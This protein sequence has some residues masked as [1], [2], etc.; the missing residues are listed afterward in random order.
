[1]VV[2]GGAI[3]ELVALCKTGSEAAKGY[4]AAVVSELARDATEDRLAAISAANGIP[5]L[6][7]L[8]STGNL[9]AKERA[10]NALWHLTV[11]KANCDA[12]AKAGGIPSLAQLLDD[13][14]SASHEHAIGTLTRLAESQTSQT[15]IA[16]KLV[17]L[18]SGESDG[19]QRRCAHMLCELS[20]LNGAPVRIVNAGAISP[21][22]AILSKSSKEAKEEAISA[23]SGLAANEPS[24][25]LAIATGLVKLLGLEKEEAQT[26]LDRI[27][28]KFAAAQVRGI[29]ITPRTSR[30][31]VGVLPLPHLL[32]PSLAL[33]SRSL[34]RRSPL[35][36]PQAPP[37]SSSAS[38]PLLSPRTPVPLRISAPA[39]PR[40][41][42]LGTL[43]RRRQRHPPQRHASQKRAP[44][45]RLAP[46]RRAP[47]RSGRA[48]Q[49]VP[50][51]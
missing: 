49:P 33:S 21:L 16:K 28:G 45:R 35:P 51:V 46:R 12:I 43:K 15:I 50:P 31:R 32:L 30:L 24:N 1:M 14:P 29:L 9:I 23:L 17:S 38:H 34:S 19:T 48:A 20:I 11:S 40:W 44:P 22:V 37:N 4:A 36:P 8:V 3:A 41:S 47:N 5:P 42:T 26:Q 10:A 25:Q 6:I 18:L 39:S 7:T 2:E 13:G 27:M